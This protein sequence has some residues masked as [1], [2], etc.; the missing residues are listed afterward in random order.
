MG[1]MIDVMCLDWMVN[2]YV[3]I[4]IYM[5]T[6]HGGDMWWYDVDIPARLQVISLLGSK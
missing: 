2:V 3:Y 5:R 1:L 6:H 4:Y